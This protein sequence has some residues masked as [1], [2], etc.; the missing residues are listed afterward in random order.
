MI[1][2]NGDPFPA[3]HDLRIFEPKKKQMIYLSLG[4]NI[5]DRWEFL[6]LALGMIEYR[7]GSI[8]CISS[9][10]ETPPWGFEST[11]FYNA[12]LGIHSILSPEEV[13]TELL[14]IETFLGRERSV[15]EGYQARTIDLDILFFEKQSIN[16]TSLTIPHPR[17]ELR[18]FILTPL[19]EIAPDY[20]HPI[21]SLRIDQLNENCEDTAIITRLSRTLQLPKKRSFVAIE[22]MIGVG[23]TAF[24]HRL[25]EALGGSLLLENFYENPYLVDFYKNPK[26]FALRVETAFLTDR[27]AQYNAFFLNEKVSP[28]IAD[29]SLDK[30]LLFAKQNLTA[31]D[32]DMYRTDYLNV[33]K[34]QPKPELVLLLKQSVSRAL[35]NIQQRGRDF[36]QKIAASYLSSLEK[37][38]EEW[39]KT[40]PTNCLNLDLTTVDFV[41]QPEEFYPLLLAFFRH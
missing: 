29:Y 26:A 20:V 31:T 23:K 6:E 19:A 25:N 4:S 18:K 11:P 21:L 35:T 3:L 39:E 1:Q 7:I 12:C 36:E 30:S 24:A 32:F 38:Y 15:S 5:G 9:V 33:T 10:Y 16:T 14:S 34:T 2:K 8:Q 17:V 27:I 22:G 13:L 37:A 40:T 41:E 28:V